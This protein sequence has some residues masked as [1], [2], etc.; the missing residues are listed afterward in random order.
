LDV[1]KMN[2]LG[3]LVLA[4]AGL[5]GAQAATVNAV[6]GWNLLGYSDTADVNVADAFGNASNVLTVWKWDATNAKWAFY[7]PSP[8]LADGGQ[9][10]ALSKGYSFLTTIKPGE[11]FWVNAKQAFS[12]TLPAPAAPVNAE[13]LSGI[14]TTMTSFQNQFANG[15]PTSTAGLDALIDTTFMQ[16]GANKTMFLQAML[17]PGNGP[18]PGTT[19]NNITLVNPTDAGA[20]ANDATHQ[21]FTFAV[22]NQN[23]PDA[24]WLAI[25]NAAGAWLVAG[26]QR[27]FHFYVSAQ[28]A[29]YVATGGSA[30]Y[31]NQINVG[32]EQLPSDV[33]Q[34]VLTGPGVMPP[35]GLLIYSAGVGQI[36]PQ[37][38][39]ANTS[40]NCIDPAAASTGSQYT[41]HT[42]TASSGTT[43]V[44]TYTNRLPLGP[45]ASGLLAGLAY[46]SISSVTGTWAAGSTVSVTWT[47]AANTWGDWIDIGAWNQ[48]TRLFTNV[49]VDISGSMGTTTNFTVPSYSGTFTNRHVWLSVRD[50]NGNRL[51]LDYPL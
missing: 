38:C 34:V 17:Q 7:S 1:F 27:A 3:V 43:A 12:A 29:K 40:T 45:V 36:F 13:A 22:S 2:Q 49:G 19:F 8:S 48:N 14:T 39:N 16:G 26:D 47:A 20:V 21:W 15:L 9:A 46:P 31:N 5:G 35:S 50:A 25:K 30:S 18:T 51:A 44:H 32:V 37:P 23:G 4:A 24:A 11:G 41:I 33:A 42:Y 28:A 10:Y 6:T